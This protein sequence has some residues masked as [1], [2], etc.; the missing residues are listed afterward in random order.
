YLTRG[1]KSEAASQL[2]LTAGAATA[3]A[4]LPEAYHPRVVDLL[5]DACRQTMAADVQ[6]ALAFAVA[7]MR[8]DWALEGLK[9][10]A[11]D[12]AVPVRLAAV[13][14]LEL[15]RGEAAYQLLQEIA[16]HDDDRRA[17]EAAAEALK[18]SEIDTGRIEVRIQDQ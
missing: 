1:E 10:M 17:V 18:P 7:S 15:R 5:I 2:Y 9:R 14:A 6:E 4:S 13:A 3:L 8:S 16:A 11:S 12:E